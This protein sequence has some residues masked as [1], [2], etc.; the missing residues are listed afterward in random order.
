MRANVDAACALA[1]Y[2]MEG[3]LDVRNE[4]PSLLGLRIAGWLDDEAMVTHLR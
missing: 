1:L 3:A 2:W 4:A